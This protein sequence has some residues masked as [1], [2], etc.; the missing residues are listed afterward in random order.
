METDIVTE[1]LLRPF[2]ERPTIEVARDLIGKLL[3]HE[4]DSERLV[5][6][7]V[8]TEAYRED[9]PACHAWREI[10]RRI[11]NSAVPWRGDVLMGEPGLAYIYLNYGMYWLLNV[12]TEPPGTGAAVLIRAV[13][14][15][16]GIDIMRAR[17]GVRK[18]SDLTNGPGKLTLAFDIDAR[19]HRK[20]LTEPPLY[21]ASSLTE[22]NLPI[23]SSVRIG[24]T[25][26]AGL[27]WRFYVPGN[28]WVSRGV[29]S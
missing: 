25:R 3:V 14:P 22:P 19:Y 17:R 26:G 13:E 2:F 6:R 12:V 11:G 20:P 7:I 10:K 15:L 16:Q 27:P 1:P 9:D 23:E 18:E 5:G 28:V 4:R 29:R 24:I 8:E 21:L